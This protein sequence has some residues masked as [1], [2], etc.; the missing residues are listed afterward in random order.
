[1]SGSPFFFPLPLFLF[2]PCDFPKA[3]ESVMMPK[4]FAKSLLPLMVASSSSVMAGQF[5]IGAGMAGLAGSGEEEYTQGSSSRTYDYS[6][7]NASIRLGYQ[8]S[9]ANRLELSIGSIDV[10]Y[11]ENYEDETYSGFDVDYY[12]VWGESIKPYLMVGLGSYTFEDSAQYFSDNDDL[13]GLA[14]NFGGGVIWQFHEHLDVELG[15]KFKSISWQD[16]TDGYNTYETQST[17][18]GIDAAVHVLF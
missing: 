8:W 1:M 11:D 17:H 5:Y 12:F 2:A 9:Y 16:A 18:S 14:F 15:Y 13:S 4:I 3:Q 10:E 7:S 6:Y